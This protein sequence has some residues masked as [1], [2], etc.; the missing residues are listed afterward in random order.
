MDAVKKKMHL[1]GFMLHCPMN[2]TVLSWAHPW[3]KVGYAWTE[4]EFW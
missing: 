2:H 1:V 3:D 4:P